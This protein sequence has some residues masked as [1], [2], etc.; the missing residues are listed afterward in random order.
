MPSKSSP[1]GTIPSVVRAL[2]RL[3]GDIAPPPPRSAFEWVLWENIA[4]LANDE[5]RADAFALLSRE[6]GTEPKAILRASAATLRNVAAHGILAERSTAKLVDA[7]RTV[8]DE[9]GGSLD[10]VLDEP[11]RDAIRALRRLPGIGE[12][13]AEKILLFAGGQSWLAPDSNALRVLCCVGLVDERPSYAA[14]YAAA[15]RRAEAE[16]EGGVAA[17]QRAH[18]ALRRHG[19]LVCTRTK[20]ACGRCPLAVTC[21]HAPTVLTVTPPP[22]RAGCRT[23]KA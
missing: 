23:G 5:R 9:F 19:Q 6:V 2:V 11:P 7:A 22:A 20:P 16:I 8:I 18:L 13:A 15:R 10:G 4:Y 3:H 21:R 14:T 17:Y 1:D 12:P